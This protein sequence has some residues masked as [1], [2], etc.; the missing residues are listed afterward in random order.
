MRTL[1]VAILIPTLC[2][3]GGGC[4]LYLLDVSTHTFQMH[5]S[6]IIFLPLLG[7]VTVMFFRR[8]PA[9]GT[10]AIVADLHSE[11]SRWSWI[12]AP[13]VILFSSL[14]QL[15]GASTGREGTALQFGA[16]TAD[17]LFQKLR[18]NGPRELYL[19]MGL[20]AGF[21]AVFHAPLAGALFAMEIKKEQRRW[22]WFP[23]CVAVAFLAAVLVQWMGFQPPEPPPFIVLAQ[24]L[25]AVG[26]LIVLALMLTLTARFLIR[27]FQ[28]AEVFFRRVGPVTAVLMGTITVC[29]LT[30]LLGTTLHNG[31]GTQLIQQSYASP[32][33]WTDS[34]TKSV[35]TVLSSVSGLRGG[36]VTPILSIGAIIGRIAADLAIVPP[37]FLIPLGV[38]GLFAAMARVPLCGALLAVEL[39]GAETLLPALL[40]CSLA[41]ILTGRRRLYKSEHVL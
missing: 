31:L 40:V 13:A 17:R 33:Q 10:A 29:V 15:F 9:P 37:D 25:P 30:F 19:R 24:P 16:I 34:L 11:K 23:L 6:L 2:A 14:S 26:G 28:A 20:A 18:P 7:I 35:M 38:T 41:S 12:G 36:E 4:F 1:L 32:L 3:I 21:A 8:W 22:V 39:F 27:F 5:S